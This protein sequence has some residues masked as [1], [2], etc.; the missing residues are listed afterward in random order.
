M[1]DLIQWAWSVANSGFQVGGGWSLL[2]IFVGFFFALSGF[3]KL[4]NQEKHEQMVRAM[5]HAKVPKP[6]PMAW[7]VSAN[8]FVWGLMLIG[9][10][11]LGVAATALFIIMLVAIKSELASRIEAASPFTGWPFLGKCAAIFCM[12]E[13][14]YACILLAILLG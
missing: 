6:R 13:A 4:F 7:F 8:E 11:F 12:A 5:I 2:H 1:H 3:H 14:I 9:H 10:N